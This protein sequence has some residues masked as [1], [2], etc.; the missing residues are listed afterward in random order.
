MGIKHKLMKK[1]RERKYRQLIE[2]FKFDDNTKILDIGVNDTEYSPVDNYFEKRY[3]KSKNITVLAVKKLIEFPERYPDISTVEYPGGC[4]PF[5]DKSFDIVMS[6]AVIEHVGGFNK[7]V[8]FINEMIRVGHKIYFTTPAK[9]FPLEIHTNYPCIH[10]LPKIIFNKIITFLG[11][12]WASGD[13]MNLLY[14]KNLEQ[15]L[16]SSDVNTYRIITHRLL[17]FPLHYIVVA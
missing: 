9:E 14:R 4:F 6:N 5:P 16:E 7:Q 1:S 12:G 11:K 13:Y 3:P 2:I 17:F 15:L 10:Y 8:E